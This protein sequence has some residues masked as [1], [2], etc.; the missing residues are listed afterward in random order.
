MF[1]VELR[2]VTLQYCFLLRLNTKKHLKIFI[3]ITG[4]ANLHH[5]LYSSIISYS[6]PQRHR[7][8]S[9]AQNKN[10]LR[11]CYWDDCMSTECH[12]TGWNKWD[13]KIVLLELLELVH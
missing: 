10:V 3:Q 9:H 6:K 7:F 1:L 5:W 12:W 13:Q 4:F 8:N 11:I 2:L